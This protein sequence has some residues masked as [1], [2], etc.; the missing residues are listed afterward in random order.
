M[1]L[2]S[3]G[4]M[5]SMLAVA[6]LLLQTFISLPGACGCSSDAV[7]VARSYCDQKAVGRVEKGPQEETAS[8]QET[9]AT[10]CCDNGVCGSAATASDCLGNCQCGEQDAGAPVAPA[11]SPKPSPR[12]VDFAFHVPHLAVHS[13][14]LSPKRVASRT[15]PRDKSTEESVQALLCIWR[16]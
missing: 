11:E 4:R 16:I 1:A 9:S 5:T 15:P 3:R 13:A 8:P 2:S 10:S 14:A 12:D 6:V 7:Q